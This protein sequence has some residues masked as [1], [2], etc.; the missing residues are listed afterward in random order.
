MNPEHACQVL[1]LAVDGWQVKCRAAESEAAALREE[2]ERLRANSRDALAEQLSAQLAE[3]RLAAAEEILKKIGSEVNERSLAAVSEPKTED[4]ATLSGRYHVCVYLLRNVFE[5]LK[6]TTVTVD[7]APENCVH[8]RLT[9]ADAKISRLEADNRAM[10]NELAQV[11]R[12]PAGHST[13]PMVHFMNEAARLGAVDRLN[14]E[15]RNRV[16]STENQLKTANTKITEM[17][18]F[19]DN[20]Q[21]CIVMQTE[22][23]KS[24][25]KEAE[26]LRIDRQRLLTALDK[27]LTVAEDSCIVE[28]ELR[29]YLKQFCREAGLEV[30]E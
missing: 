24:A 19:N 14:A 5:A 17:Q 23:S 9:K 6:G 18:L 16:A 29:R 12:G 10:K 3:K 27:V 21:R 13:Q 15:Y 11:G 26:A 25:I 7:V 22:A 2:V 20:A 1:A 28:D 8:S 30:K 4:Q